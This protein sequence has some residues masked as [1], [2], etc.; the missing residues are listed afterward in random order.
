[1]AFNEMWGALD[2]KFAEPGVVEGLM[3]YKK[4]AAANKGVLVFHRGIVRLKQ[5][6]GNYHVR[7]LEFVLGDLL[8]ASDAEL[9][10]AALPGGDGFYHVY[11]HPVLDANKLTTAVVLRV[12]GKLN[13]H[14]VLPAAAVASMAEALAGDDPGAT[15]AGNVAPEPKVAA[16]AFKMVSAVPDSDF[17][18]GRSIR[19]CTVKVESNEITE[20]SVEG[21][22]RV[23]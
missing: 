13:K 2:S 8:A 17:Y 19:L 6:V 20:I 3:P 16:G 14:G 4:D 12:G 22:H 15:V 5:A 18:P 23:R 11:A 1:M 9:D 21:V 10:L 7:S